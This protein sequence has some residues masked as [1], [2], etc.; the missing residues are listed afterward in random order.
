MGKKSKKR[1]KDNKPR[2]I[3]IC[4]RCHAYWISDDDPICIHCEIYGDPQNE[5]A[6]RMRRWK[7]S[8]SSDIN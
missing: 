8:E 1:K 3:F 2:P 7:E 5:S 6:V 4:S